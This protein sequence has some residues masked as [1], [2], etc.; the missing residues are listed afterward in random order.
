V[1]ELDAQE[2]RIAMRQPGQGADG[3]EPLARFARVPLT[4]S[5]FYPEL[6]RFVRYEADP[7]AAPSAPAGAPSAPRRPTP[8]VEATAA[9][10]EAG[11]TIIAVL[12]GGP[13]AGRRLEAEVVEG[14]PP[15]TIDV[16]ADDGSTCRY[17]LAEWAQAGPSAVYTFLYAV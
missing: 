8:S 13:L 5:E 15:K 10:R 9:A 4:T 7:F 16:E 2:V 6:E 14:R 17:G 1:I 3:E 11:P 12:E